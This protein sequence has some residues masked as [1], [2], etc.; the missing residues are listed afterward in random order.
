MRER[1]T[2]ANNNDNRDFDVTKTLDLKPKSIIAT[3]YSSKAKPTKKKP[4]KQS[5]SF[6][7]CPRP[8]Q[9]YSAF[10]GASQT[11]Y[12]PKLDCVLV[13]S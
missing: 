12:H 1:T 13:E 8:S 2:T 5:A 11:S 9:D 6:L 7:A 4:L 3:H 10:E